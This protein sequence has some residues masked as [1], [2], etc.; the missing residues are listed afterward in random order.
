[1]GTAIVGEDAEFIEFL[2]VPV[3][4]IFTGTVPGEKLHGNPLH[5]VPAAAAI[6]SVSLTWRT[7]PGLGWLLS[8]AGKGLKLLLF[9][10]HT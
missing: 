10:I 5:H 3:Y 1:M 7:K 2:Q 4:I 9:K 6:V 8:K